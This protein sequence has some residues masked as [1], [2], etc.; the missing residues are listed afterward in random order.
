M[1]SKLD[2]GSIYIKGV[3]LLKGDILIVTFICML[4]VAIFI[5]MLPEANESNRLEVYADGEL[6]YNIELIDGVEQTIEI[7]EFVHNTIEISG[8]KVRIIES[9]CYDHVCENTGYI[10]K[11]G[12]IIVCMPNKLLLKIV[13]N[14]EESEYDAVVG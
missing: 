4:A 11:V 8:T 6:I 2:N 7:E 5:L 9:T 14:E 12:E 13:G 3:K 1:K 10:S